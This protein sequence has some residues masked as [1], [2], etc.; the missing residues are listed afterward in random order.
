MSHQSICLLWRTNGEG[1]EKDRKHGECGG[2]VLGI[3]LL[4]HVKEVER[5]IP[6]EID[7]LPKLALQI[8]TPFLK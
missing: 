6:L 7:Y 1:K 2:E 3:V 8:S 4:P 5:V